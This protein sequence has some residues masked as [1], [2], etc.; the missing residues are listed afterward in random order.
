[1]SGI[2]EAIDAL[3][4]AA[5]QA[6]LLRGA[7]SS[8]FLMHCAE[9][10]AV[11]AL[12]TAAGL[13]AVRVRDLCVALHTAGVLET[14]HADRYRVSATYAPLLR[15]GMDIQFASDLAG[16]AVEERLLAEAFS[17]DGPTR[18]AD[19]DAADRIA[20]AAS[21]TVAPSTEQARSGIRT[22]I[23]SVPPWWTALTADGA[24]YLELGCGVAGGMLTYV[25][26]YP[27]LR[28]VGVDLAADLLARA[29]TDAVR[30]GVAD[31]VRLV[32]EDAG[33]FNDPEPFD[34]VYWS[35]YFFPVGTRE[36]T[37]ANAYQRLRPGGV[38]IAPV[39]FPPGSDP[40][41]P[42]NALD[43]VLAR[44]WDVPLVSAEKLS[45]ELETAGFVDPGVYRTRFTVV[46]ARRPRRP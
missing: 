20:F 18:Y 9:D 36:R 13:D 40:A 10:I 34:S 23:E 19:L 26:V 12:A 28:A 8:G 30:L 38:I 6:A 2:S 46:V 27:S 7:L 4:L 22:L 37:M 14:D 41:D 32:H 33:S 15:D 39:M 35:Q 24:R 31:R 21:V 43:V 1:M 42:G 5:R 44:G 25:Q 29:R 45:A 17:P 3:T 16:V 11:E